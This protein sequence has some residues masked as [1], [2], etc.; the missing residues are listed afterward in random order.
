[1][2]AVHVASA[3]NEVAQAL[4][5][6]A[7][8]T[9]S[10]H[11]IQAIETLNLEAQTE[12]QNQLAWS[13]TF[14]GMEILTNPTIHYRTATSVVLS[15][16]QAKVLTNDLKNYKMWREHVRLASDPLANSCNNMNV[17]VNNAS[18]SITPKVDHRIVTS[19]YASRS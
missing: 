13:R 6:T 19:F 7:T 15:N 11:G 3:A 18:M 8:V 14:S 17:T 12:S 2:S 5:S 10:K 4:P 16:S 9:V 1:M